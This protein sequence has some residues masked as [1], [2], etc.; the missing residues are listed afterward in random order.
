MK[1]AAVEQFVK[2][3]YPSIKRPEFNDP[4]N[5]DVKFIDSFG[6]RTNFLAVVSSTGDDG[7]L[8]VEHLSIVIDDCCNGSNINDPNNIRVTE[9]AFKDMIVR[10]YTTR[11][12]DVSGYELQWIDGDTYEYKIGPNYEPETTSVYVNRVDE[13]LYN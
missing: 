1:N 2:S 8:L 3:L 7:A 9:S 5:F 6:I 11:D 12:Y 13:Y 10:Q 4:H